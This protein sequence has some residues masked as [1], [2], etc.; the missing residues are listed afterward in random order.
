MKD[1]TI[2]LDGG[3]GGEDIFEAAS[4]AEALEL[5]MDFAA[6]GVW[7]E[8]AEKED[9]LVTVEDEDGDEVA[10]GTYAIPTAEDEGEYST[11]QIVRVGGNFYYRHSNGGSRGA[12]DRM[13]GDGVWR[14]YPV[15]PSRQIDVTEARAI[16][17]DWGFE[18][19]EVGK[20]T[21]D[22]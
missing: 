10:R 18:P 14:D 15:E 6:D 17:L 20:M 9:V 1:Y 16:L 4:P 19:R 12:H 8:D 13:C 5:E 21:R 3:M 11:E 22:R 7:G 2:K